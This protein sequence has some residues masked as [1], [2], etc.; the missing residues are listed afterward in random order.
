[1]GHRPGEGAG[2]CMAE[3]ILMFDTDD[4]KGRPGRYRARHS[5]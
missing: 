4:E 5:L 1:M 3:S 2:Q